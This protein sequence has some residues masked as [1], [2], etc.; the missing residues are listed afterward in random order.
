MLGGTRGQGAFSSTGQAE[1]GLLCSPIMM[2]LARESPWEV[3]WSSL[4]RRSFK[5][6]QMR[7]KP[8]SF[9]VWVLREPQ[10]LET[11]LTTAFL[12]HCQKDSAFDTLHQASLE[13]VSYLSPRIRKDTPVLLSACTE[14]FHKQ[15]LQGKTRTYGQYMNTWT[16]W[17]AAPRASWRCLQPYE[18]C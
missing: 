11:S 17:T 16:T 7:L 10:L 1:E 4:S 6:E 14:V 12:Q 18:M 15:R 5:L 3:L 8:G 13:P 9:S 2:D